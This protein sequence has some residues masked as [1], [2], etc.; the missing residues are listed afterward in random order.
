MK[1]ILAHTL[2]IEH[3]SCHWK[4]FKGFHSNGVFLP[5]Y[6]CSHH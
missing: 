6:K 2:N 4:L 5:Y 1:I 3:F